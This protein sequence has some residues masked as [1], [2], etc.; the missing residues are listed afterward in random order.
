MTMLVQDFVKA[1]N[2]ADLSLRQVF[3]G[4]LLVLANRRIENMS[5]QDIG[6]KSL[7]CLAATGLDGENLNW[8]IAADLVN[9]EAPVMMAAERFGVEYPIGK[10]VWRVRRALGISGLVEATKQ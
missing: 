1:L 10:L 6:M 5:Q 8:Q 3:T 7:Q 4:R 2:G 9:N